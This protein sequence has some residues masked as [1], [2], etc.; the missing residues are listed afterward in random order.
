MFSSLFWCS[1]Q[2]LQNFYI[3]EVYS[4]LPLPALE[5]RKFASKTLLR[6]SKKSRK[7]AAIL[8]QLYSIFCRENANCIYCCILLLII[9]FDCL[10]TAIVKELKYGIWTLLK[11]FRHLYLGTCQFQFQYTIFCSVV[12]IWTEV[13]I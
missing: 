7:N 11:R 3:P 5:N 9:F 6:K 13:Y 1:G 8:W 2:F 4:C 12:V 10:H